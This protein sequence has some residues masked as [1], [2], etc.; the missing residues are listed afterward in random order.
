MLNQNAAHHSEGGRK[1]YFLPPKLSL[2]GFS[3]E[4]R[5]WRGFR[6]NDDFRE[7]SWAQFRT[8]EPAI[9]IPSPNA[10]ETMNVFDRGA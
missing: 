8:A 1:F 3:T 4:K 7:K 10:T 2:T 6:R 5:F 9:E